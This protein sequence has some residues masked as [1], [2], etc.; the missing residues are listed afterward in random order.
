MCEL[1]QISQLL[2]G[3]IELLILR[4]AGRVA[5]YAGRKC[6]T[7]PTHIVNAVELLQSVVSSADLVV[8]AQFF[9][10]CGEQFARVLH[11]ILRGTIDYPKRSYSSSFLFF[12]VPSIYY[13]GPPSPAPSLS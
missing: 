2:L 4:F 8:D 6:S 13:L 10:L 5:S 9:K 3:P 7:F 12:P 11:N 1:A